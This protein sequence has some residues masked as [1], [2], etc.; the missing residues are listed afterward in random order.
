MPPISALRKCVY[1]FVCN[2]TGVQTCPVT[3]LP[4][5]RGTPRPAV[6]V[7]QMDRPAVMPAPEMFIQGYPKDGSAAP[8]GTPAC[9]GRDRTLAPRSRRGKRR[10]GRAG[11]GTPA[12]AVSLPRAACDPD[13]GGGALALALPL[14]VAGPHVVD[15]HGLIGD[16]VVGLH[17]RAGPALPSR[18]AA[19]GTGSWIHRLRTAEPPD[20]VAPHPSHPQCATYAGPA[21]LS[22]GSVSQPITAPTWVD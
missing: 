7:D 10:A 19:G 12:P 14:P 21:G 9:S 6:Q 22:G 17:G 1:V 15:D 20:P 11:L 8:P 2:S 4:V 13:P 18:R 3:T 5:L 16:D